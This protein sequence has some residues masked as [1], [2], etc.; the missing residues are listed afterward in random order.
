MIPDP[1]GFGV[2]AEARIGWDTRFVARMSPA[3][4]ALTAAGTEIAFTMALVRDLVGPVPVLAGHLA[5]CV[6]IGL[7]AAGATN[8]PKEAAALAHLTLWTFVAGPLGSLLALALTIFGSI[9]GKPAP[10][11]DFASWVEVTGDLECPTACHRLSRDLRDG[12]L[13][14]GSASAVPAL[15]DVLAAGTRDAKFE[16]LAI[17]GRRFDPSLSHVIRAAIQD[18]DPSV[19]VLASTV[20]AKLQTRFSR[21]LIALEAAAARTSG[22][23]APWLELAKAR[24][25]YAESG[26]TERLQAH[27]EMRA[28][29][30]AARRAVAADPDSEEALALLAELEVADGSSCAACPLEFMP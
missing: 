26:L 15:A 4:V 20:L 10:A 12:R 14:I 30:L 27:T 3:W 23:A 21:A 28:A 9:A 18:T 2:A 29:C 5:L 17:V 1:D 19:R 13:R 24:R 25:A 8:R 16:A 11:V 7:R 6:L 22:E